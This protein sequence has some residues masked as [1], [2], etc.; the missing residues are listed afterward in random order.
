M[1]MKAILAAVSSSAAPPII[2]FSAGQPNSPAHNAEPP[3]MIIRSLP[4]VSPSPHNIPPLLTYNQS[5][6]EA[7]MAARQIPIEASA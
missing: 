4:T 3:R 7:A 5:D 1:T 2:T 6:D